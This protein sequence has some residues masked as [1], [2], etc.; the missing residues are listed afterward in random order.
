MIEQE[1]KIFKYSTRPYFCNTGL[2]NFSVWTNTTCL[3]EEEFEQRMQ[4]RYGEFKWL[5]GATEHEV[6]YE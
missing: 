6:D 2:G 1:L 4:Q 3:N 5:A